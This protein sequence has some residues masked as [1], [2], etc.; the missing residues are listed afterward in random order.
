MTV[1]CLNTNWFFYISADFGGYA[2]PASSRSTKNTHKYSTNLAKL[3]QDGETG[4][5]WTETGSDVVKR[6]DNKRAM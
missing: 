2:Q 4:S 1:V 3:K 5:D 6:E